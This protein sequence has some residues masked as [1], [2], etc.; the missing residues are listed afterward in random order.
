MATDEPATAPG[1]G[2][3][4]L[5]DRLHAVLVGGMEPVTVELVGYRPEW[6]RIFERERDRVRAALGRVAKRI[7]HVG[8]TAVPGLA[9]KDVV[10]VVVTVDDVEAE[11]YAAAV[12]CLGYTLR[13]R[14]PGHRCFRLMEPRVN[15]H[16]WGDDDPEV[17][18]YVVFRDRLRS[19]ADERALY[20]RVKRDLAGREYKDVNFYADAKGD[21]IRAIL[22]RAG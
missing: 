21:V 10:D 1:A 12:E 5:D 19:H 6:P 20:E 14:E 15:L 13:V 17:E 11:E 7:E 18:R 9:A 2:E 16:V 3:G 8:S 4:H 22:A